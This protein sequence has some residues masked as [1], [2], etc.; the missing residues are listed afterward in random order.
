[1]SSDSGVNLLVLSSINPEEGRTLF[2]E[3][4][5]VTGGGTDT[6]NYKDRREHV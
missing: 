5:T 6:W 1:M 3:T 4:D 2:A